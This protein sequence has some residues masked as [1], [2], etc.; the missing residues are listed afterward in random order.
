MIRKMAR[1]PIVKSTLKLY[2]NI[3]G[4]LKKVSQTKKALVFL[5]K[6]LML[7]MKPPQA[8]QAEVEATKE[9]VSAIQYN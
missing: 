6:V 5:K 3:P 9:A 2:H 1:Y 4:F 8:T 7:R